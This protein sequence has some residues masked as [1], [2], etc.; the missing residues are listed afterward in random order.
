VKD[1]IPDKS[2]SIYSWNDSVRYPVAIEFPVFSI[3][4]CSGNFQLNVHCNDPEP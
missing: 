4:A 3:P 1:R 2:S